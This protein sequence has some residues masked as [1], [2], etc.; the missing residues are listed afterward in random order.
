MTLTATVL[1]LCAGSLKPLADGKISGIDK[2][3]REGEIRITRLGLEGDVQADRKHH[4]GEHMAVHHYSADHY[5]YW[6]KQLPH[7]LRLAEPGAFGENIHA[8]GLTEQDVYIGDRYRLGSSLLEVSMGRQPCSTLERHLGQKDM[9]RRIIS[10]H[11][12]GW[13][14]RVIEEGCATAGDQLALVER[15]QERWSIERAFSY[16]FDRH[17]SGDSSEGNDLLSLERLGPQWR[18]K[19]A[20]RRA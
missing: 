9:V 4:G 19:V 16:L 11:R 8:T 3:A 20:A 15:S 12:C 18:A 5:A 6:R 14:Y 1:A 2:R 10:N 7:V 13:Y 17:Y